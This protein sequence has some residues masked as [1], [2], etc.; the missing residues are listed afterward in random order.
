MIEVKDMFGDIVLKF[1]TE[2]KEFMYTDELEDK[3][4]DALVNDWADLDFLTSEAI[5]FKVAPGIDLVKNHK[6]SNQIANIMINR[7]GWRKGTKKI[8]GVAKRGY[9]RKH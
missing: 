1:R 8:N 5:G 9:T 6:I 3:I 2:W 7:F 4:E